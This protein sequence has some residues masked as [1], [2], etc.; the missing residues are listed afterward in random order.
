MNG[1]LTL[2]FEELDLESGTYDRE[3]AI[4]LNRCMREWLGW[5]DYRQELYSALGF[6]RTCPTEAALADAVRRWQQTQ[7]LTPDGI[8]GLQTLNSLHTHLGK[9]VLAAEPARPPW[10]LWDPSPNFSGRDGRA[11][12]T[13]VLHATSGGSVK[14]AM[15]RFKN[16]RSEASAHFIILR[17]GVILQLVELDQASWHTSTQSTGI[18][19]MNQRSIGI[20]IVNP[21][22]RMGSGAVKV[23]DDETGSGTMWTCVRSARVIPQKPLAAYYRPRAV[24]RFVPFSE[25][26]YRTLIRLVRYLISCMPTITLITGHEHLYKW[27]GPGKKFKNRVDP[28]G[29]FEWTRLETALSGT[30]PGVIC[31]QVSRLTAGNN[32]SNPAW[33]DQCRGLP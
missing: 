16:R 15:Q 26:Q 30:F 20:E 18:A 25:A 4:R 14:G 5:S 28:G 13:I 3:K 11:I 27:H 31:H 17:N 32:R 33:V 6:P 19:G 24:E 21:G 22:G 2:A 1:P 7:R 23:C 12:D 8:L 10:I 29:Q 9:P